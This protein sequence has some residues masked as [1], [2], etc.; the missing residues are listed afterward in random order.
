MLYGTRC[1]TCVPSGVSP[2]IGSSYSGGG[3]TVDAV[4]VALSSTMSVMSAV[5]RDRDRIFGTV[6]GCEPGL[7]VE[8]R[9]DV[10]LDEQHRL[11]EVVDVEQLR[12]ERIAAV[13][14]L[15]LLGIEMNSHGENLNG[16]TD[17]GQAAKKEFSR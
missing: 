5:L 11:T 6:G 4:V 3:G 7:V 16:P 14:T 17:D 13:M 12:R 1:Q 2:K 9:G 15:A 8:L 10:A